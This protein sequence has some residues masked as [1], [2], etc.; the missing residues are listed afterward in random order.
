MLRTPLPWP[1]PEFCGSYPR[2]FLISSDVNCETGLAAGVHTYKYDS[3]FLVF[4]IS[5][6]MKHHGDL[7]YAEGMLRYAELHRFLVG[8]TKVPLYESGQEEIGP[9]L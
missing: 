4:P 2:E 3:D 9:G 8:G 7:W 6:V 5:S 1:L